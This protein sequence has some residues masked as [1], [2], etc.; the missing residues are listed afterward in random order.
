MLKF[1]SCERTSRAVDTTS[2]APYGDGGMKKSSVLVT[3]PLGVVT[4]NRPD[5]ADAGTVSARL[6][7][8]ADVT[9][10]RVRFTTVRF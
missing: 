3:L 9:L 7:A 10:A 1:S 4:A 5:A 8:D 2:D 6:V